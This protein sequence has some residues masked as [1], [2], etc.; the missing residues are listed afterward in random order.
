MRQFLHLTSRLPHDA[1]EWV[2]VP[3]GPL[4]C[5]TVLSPLDLRFRGCSEAKYMFDY[6]CDTEFQS[7]DVLDPS[8]ATTQVTVDV[9]DPSGANTQVIVDVLVQ[10]GTTT[11]VTVDV[12]DP[13]G[14]TTVHR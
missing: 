1:K 14:T 6:G 7:V 13:S 8:G 12:L 4:K 11:Q 5:L 10:T 2:R 3:M 9:L